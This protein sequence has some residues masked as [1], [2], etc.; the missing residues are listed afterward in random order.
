M[1]DLTGAP[2]F[3]LGI[4]E[5]GQDVTWQKLVEGEK[6]NYL[7]AA[8]AGATEASAEMLEEL[9]LVAQHSYGLL[10]A[11]EIT[12]MFGDQVRLVQLRNPWGNFEW[13]GDWSD[14]SD[15]WTDDIKQQCAYNDDAG[16]FWMSFAD[17]CHYFSRVQIAMIN[18]DFHYSY[19]KASH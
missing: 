5:E 12:D 18:D 4:E 9:G 8:S 13:Q 2:S 1:N 15:L 14:K 16:L 6:K 3:D 7:M 17:M 10:K 11:V 19:M